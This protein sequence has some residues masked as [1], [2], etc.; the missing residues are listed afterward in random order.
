MHKLHLNSKLALGLLTTALL[1]ASLPTHATTLSASAGS[2]IETGEVDREIAISAET[3][4]VN[5]WHN[6]R[7]RFVNAQNGQ[8]MDWHF[9]M[10]RRSSVIE[11][12]PVAT[13]LLDK[14]R[15]TVYVSPDPRYCGQ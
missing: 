4:F 9:D 3:R 11:F 15:L 8:R 7:I 2:P 14:Q 6:E 10:V 12:Q 13:A 1:A 5:V